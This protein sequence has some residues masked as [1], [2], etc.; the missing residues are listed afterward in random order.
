MKHT[1]I[2]AATALLLAACTQ[3]ELSSPTGGVEGALPEGKYPLELTATGMQA[4]AT[5]STRGTI[6]GNWE[7]AQGKKV[8]V[9]VNGETKEYTLTSSGDYKTATL[10]SDDPF[11]WT[12]TDETKTVEAWYPCLTTLPEKWEVPADQSAGMPTDKDFLYAK[13]TI[14]FSSRNEAELTFEH[15]LAK[16]VINIQQSDYLDSYDDELSVQLTGLLTIGK[17]TH[18]ADNILIQ[19]DNSTGGTSIT[20]HRLDTPADG[21]FASYEAL[22]IP[23]LCRTTNRTFTIEVH[24][25]DA[26]YKVEIFELT[27]L[28][29]SYSFYANYVHTFDIT[30]KAEGLEVSVDTIQDWTDGGGESGN[31]TDPGDGYTVSEDGSTYTVY[32][33][34]GL[35]AWAEAAQGNPSLNCTLTHDIDLSGSEW[36]P[37]A[38]GDIDTYYTGTF[39]GNGHTI[40]NLAITK[41][42]LYFGDDC[43]M[44]GRVGT[45]AT[46][47]NLTLKN[48]SLNVSADRENA[49]LGIGALAGVNQGTISN[50]KVSGNIFVTNNEIG[51][52]GGVVGQME[53]GVI[54]Y[55][56][57]SASIQGGNS[58]YVGGVLGG[59]YATAT[60]IKGC[61]FSGSVTAGNTVGGIAGYCR[62][63]NDMTG[64]Y[65]VGELSSA[66]YYTGGITGYLQFAGVA[67]SCYWDGF[68]GESVGRCNETDPFSGAYKIDGST[69]TWQT[70]TEAMNTALGADSE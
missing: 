29:N 51:Y 41:E 12:S 33:A 39:D 57:S 23:Q 36:E 62:F 45:N 20:P 67:G 65:S 35:M 22:V 49:G 19:G 26:T 9:M 54:Q 70:A 4:V 21:A 48:V 63:F 32:T 53:S 60:V 15:C 28:G 31:A 1:L 64:C 68:D 2:L 43:G 6:D 52:V 27:S 24:V 42:N 25:G 56:H 18:Y 46:I 50:C 7:G 44:F 47:K 11:Y 8:A 3:D 61:S 34:D 38:F 30:V 16:V 37:V 59:E 55:C 13:Q 14:P 40:S 66:V 10:T 17:V 58:D 5:P 69:H